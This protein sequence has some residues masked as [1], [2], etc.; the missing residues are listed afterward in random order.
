LKKGI[1]DETTL[2]MEKQ[3]TITSVAQFS[4]TGQNEQP[5]EN[6]DAN[7]DEQPAEVV[8]VVKAKVTAEKP[9]ESSMEKKL[10]PKKPTAAVS[11]TTETTASPT[12][13]GIVER[14][15]AGCRRCRWSQCR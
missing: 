9:D 3:Q 7:P 8:K 10:S 2:L 12:Q 14:T 11:D 4:N 5:D 6:P 1:N 15:T 13:Q